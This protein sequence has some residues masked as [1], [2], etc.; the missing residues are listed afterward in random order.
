M[1][2]KLL[3]FS[4]ASLLAACGGN[5]IPPNTEIPIPVGCPEA[6][7]TPAGERPT[8]PLTT[9]NSETPVDVASRLWKASVLEL[10]GYIGKVEIERD[11]YRDAYRA[12]G[13]VKNQLEPSRE[14]LLDQPVQ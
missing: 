3:I 12:C 10:L 5:D 14:E 9:I 13:A 7:I 2:K 8:L 1:Y 4:I 6:N 11:G